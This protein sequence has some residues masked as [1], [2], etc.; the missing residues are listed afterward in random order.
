MTNIVTFQNV[1]GY[2][3]REE[4]AWLNAED[5][6]RGLGWTQIKNGVEYIRWETINAYLA[7]FNFPKK[8][9]KNDFIPEKNP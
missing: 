4:V 3:D 6:A 9:G 5:V 2:V 1:R 8:V 7:E